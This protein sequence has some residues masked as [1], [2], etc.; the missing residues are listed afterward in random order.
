MNGEGLLGIAPHPGDPI[1]F[2]VAVGAIAVSLVLLVLLLQALRASVTRYH[3]RRKLDEV[4]RLKDLAI[5]AG[6]LAHEI[7]HPVNSMQFA[8]ASAAGRLRK[9]AADPGEID[10]IETILEEIRGDLKRL[11]EIT[12]AFLRYARPEAQEATECD[13]RESCEFVRRFVRVELGARE[14]RLETEYP[15]QP[16]CVRMPEVH[17]RQ[18]LVNLVLNAAQASENGSTVWLRVLPGKPFVRIEV[19]DRGSGVPGDEIPNLF[20]PFHT[21]RAEGVGLGL[22]VSRRFARDAGGNVTYRRA[23]PRGSVFTVEL[24]I[25]AAQPTQPEGEASS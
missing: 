13:V 24:P 14:I 19:E 22:A 1:W 6:G 2:W 5:L 17:L 15:P 20:K 23:E 21:T 4:E 9:L 12:N 8:L 7:R 16:V 11:E 25:A 10:E 18:I 3:V